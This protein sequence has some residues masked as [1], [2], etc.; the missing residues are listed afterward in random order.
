[1][2]NAVDV[3]RRGVAVGLGILGA[4]GIAIAVSEAGVATYVS[5]AGAAGNG[6]SPLYRVSV[7][8]IAVT[9]ALTATLGL[10]RLTAVMLAVAAPAV[11]LSAAVTCTKGCPLPPHSPAQPSV[12]IHAA[13]SAAGI[14]LC[15]VAMITLAMRP[16]ETGRPARLQRVSL[17]AAA[18]AWPLLIA[19]AFGVAV[20][21]RSVFSGVAERLAIAV[22][23]TWLIL[24]AALAGRVT[25]VDG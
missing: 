11:A 9:T 4:A 2:A 10:P 22:C 13:A 3:A 12:L 14:G 17:V 19:T 8:A 20:T 6:H 18:L 15:A 21:G 5:E 23:L 7:L 25:T 1:M 24:I 16:R